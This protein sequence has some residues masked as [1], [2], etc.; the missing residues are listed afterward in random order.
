VRARR[1]RRGGAGGGA[2]NSIRLQTKG[3]LGAAVS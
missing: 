2:T 3:N 1:A